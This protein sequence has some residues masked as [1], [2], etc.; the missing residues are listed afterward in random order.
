MRGNKFELIF[1]LKIPG[2]IGEDGE[3][4]IY[5]PIKDNRPKGIVLRQRRHLLK[6][7]QRCEGR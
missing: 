5:L 3:K 2:I 4:T 7:N 1:Y 6:Q